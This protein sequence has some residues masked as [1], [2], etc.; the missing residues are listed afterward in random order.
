MKYTYAI[1]AF[2]ALTTLVSCGGSTPEEDTKVNSWEQQDTNLETNVEDTMAELTGSV[3]LDTNHAL[4]GKTLNFDIEMVKITKGTGT[5]ADTVEAGDAIEVHYTGTLEDG[6]KF[7]S[8]IDRGETLPFTVGAGQMIPGF[9]SG[10]LGMKLTEKK[11]LVLAPADAYGEYDETR[12]Q[13]VP[14]KDLASFVA[15][16][17]ELKVGEK[18][19]TQFGELTILEILPE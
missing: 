7:D 16:G 17:F 8:S 1:L 15:A 4:A 2:I 18:I 14:K 11:T 3:V 10:V 6:T 12:K 19:P 9:D 5:L 13:T